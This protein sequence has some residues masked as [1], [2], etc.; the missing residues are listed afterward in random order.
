MATTCTVKMVSAFDASGQICLQMV[1]QDLP[2]EVMVSPRVAVARQDLEDGEAPF[3]CV[4]FSTPEKR[5]IFSVEF[6]DAARLAALLTSHVVAEQLKQD[7]ERARALEDDRCAE[8]WSNP[9]W[10]GGEN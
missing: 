10:I 8:N 9:D 3:L 6:N 2:Q 5:F 4:S 7:Q 1:S